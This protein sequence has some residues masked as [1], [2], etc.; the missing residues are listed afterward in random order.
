MA[1]WR[2]SWVSAGSR[3]WASSGRGLLEAITHN[4]HQSLIERL[5]RPE[6]LSLHAVRRVGP[7]RQLHLKIRALYGEV[8][9]VFNI[10]VD[11]GA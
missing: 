8:E 9:R 6:I 7:E 5:E 4:L 1:V 3:V 11:T 2:R 10:L